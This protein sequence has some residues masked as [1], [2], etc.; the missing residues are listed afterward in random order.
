MLDSSKYNKHEAKSFSRMNS[1]F[2]FRFCF[3]PRS[4]YLLFVFT[5]FAYQSRKTSKLL[6]LKDVC[7]QCTFCLHVESLL[8]TSWKPH[9]MKRLEISRDL[10][11][12]MNG[13]KFAPI[14]VLWKRHELIMMSGVHPLYHYF[15]MKNYF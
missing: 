8:T 7:R 3:Q 15:R 12:H 9:Q 6:R 5:L 2:Y 1:L 14:W 13:G 4:S 11:S 10:S